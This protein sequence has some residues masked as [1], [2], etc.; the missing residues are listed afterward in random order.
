MQALMAA[1]VMAA[2]LFETTAVRNVHL[3][4]APDQ[5]A[6]M[7]P[8][9]DA[10]TGPPEGFPGPGRMLAPVFLT[11]DTNGDGSLSRDEFRSLASKWFA[12]W[13]RTKRGYLTADDLRAAFDDRIG[14]PGLP[15]AGPGGLTAAQD[16]A[17]RRNG[18]SAMA[19][20]DFEYVHADL[21]LDG[22]LIRD[23]GVRY[24]GNNTYMMSSESLKRPLKID[25]DH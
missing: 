1:A 12:E 9:Q 8:K 17:K 25:L 6:A 5:W 13:D 21:E 19:G 7:E 15:G 11:G 24:K 2:S 16:G 20:I 22:R 10:R 18:M 3:K 23:V 4:F 14:P